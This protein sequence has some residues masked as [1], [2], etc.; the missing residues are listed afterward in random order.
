MIVFSVESMPGGNAVQIYV[1]LI[2]LAPLSLYS[3]L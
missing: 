3:G 1:M 2:R